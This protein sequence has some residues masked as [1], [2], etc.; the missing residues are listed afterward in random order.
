MK[1]SNNIFCASV[2]ERMKIRTIYLFLILTTSVL[3][4]QSDSTRLAW[5]SPPERGRIVHV[6]TISS[7]ESLQPKKGFFSKILSLFAG[8]DRSAR[9]LVQPVGIAVGPDGRIVIADPGANCLHIINPVEKE[10]DVISDTKFGKLMSP[11]GVAF[12]PDGTLY[13]S[14]SQRGDIIVFDRDLDADVQ[15]KGQL[16]RPTGI[17]IVGNKL[18][19]VDT[20]E[21]K[22]V[23]FDLK[24]TYLSS[25]GQRGAGIGEFNYP[26]QIAERSDTSG[27]F[28]LDGLNYRVQKFDAGGKFASTFGRQG[29]VAGR[30]SSPKSIALDSDG[31]IYVTDALMD[32]IQVFNSNGELLLVVGKKGMKDGEFL[33]PGGI[34]VDRNDKIYV[35]ETLNKRIQIFQYVK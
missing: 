21:H 3:Y 29:N 35:V 14:D 34:C 30:F 10:Y 17:Q 16:N 13:V 25:F 5:P 4:G 20:G 33:S 8:N 19:V 22:V 28:V 18:Y 7:L 1:F 31:N 15:I 26:L 23:V 6:Q 11:V 27:L 32:N 24:G 12:A 9:W 2:N